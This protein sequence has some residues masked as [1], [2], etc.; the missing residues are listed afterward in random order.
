MK[1]QASLTRTGCLTVLTFLV[2]IV[3]ARS[4]AQLGPGSALVLD[5]VDVTHFFDVVK[6]AAVPSYGFRGSWVD[7]SGSMRGMARALRIGGGVRTLSCR[8]VVLTFA[9]PRPNGRA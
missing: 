5:G 8:W 3:A 9:T 2:L 6:T 1:S 4:P 7:S